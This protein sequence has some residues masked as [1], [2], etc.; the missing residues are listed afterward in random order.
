MMND[1]IKLIRT[2]VSTTLNS[3]GDYETVTTDREVF[4]GVQSVGYKEFYEAATVG[5][6]PEIKFILQ[7]Y[8][9]YDG[10]KELAYNNVKYPIIRTY[11][12]QNNM[13]E[14]VCGGG[15]REV[16]HT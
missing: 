13:L 16:A 12:T 8:E 3:V 4:C 7:D 15:V 10:E 6:K 9:D 2:T 1:V 5:M 11:R 14:I